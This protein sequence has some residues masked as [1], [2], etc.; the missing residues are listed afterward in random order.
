V[1]G[2]N[3]SIYLYPYLVRPSVFDGLY[4]SLP[5]VGN[6]SSLQVE[7][8][9][10][11]QVLLS[12]V[13]ELGQYSIDQVFGKLGISIVWNLKNGQDGA[14]RSVLMRGQA[15]TTMNYTNVRPLIKTSL[16]FAS[17]NGIVA[18]MAVSL[19]FTG[20]KFV[21]ELTDG[22]AWIVYNGD[23]SL[24]WIVSGEKTLT[25][26]SKI[27]TY[28]RVVHVTDQM[29]A[30]YDQYCNT[31][32]VRVSND[33]YV[34]ENKAKIVFSYETVGNGPFLMFVLPHHIDSMS[35]SEVVFA[36]NSGTNLKLLGTKGTMFG[37]LPVNNQIILYEELT[38]IAFDSDLSKAS[39]S[40]INELRNSLNTDQNIRP[41]DVGN[42]YFFGKEVALMGRLA[43]IA[44]QLNEST[45][46]TNI[47]QAMKQDLNSWLSGG[48]MNNS[49]PNQYVYEKTYGGIVSRMAIASKDPDEEFGNAYYNDHHFHWGYHIYAAAVIAKVDKSWATENKNRLMDLIRDY[50]SPM[51][52]K[53]FPMLRMKD[54]FTGASF[55]QGLFVFGSGVKNQESTSEAINA[56]YAM[57]LLGKVL[58]DYDIEQMGR[59]LLATE[60]RSAKTY[61]H[62]SSSNSVYDYA[63]EFKQNKMVG[64]IWET[65][66]NY[67]TWFGTNLEFIHCIQMMPFTPIMRQVLDTDF[68]KQDYQVLQQ[69]LTRSK[70]VLTEGWRGFIYM[71]HSIFDRQQARKEIDT[72]SSYDDGNCRTNTLYWVISQ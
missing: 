33:F 40:D 20:K 26:T 35:T 38:T 4:C 24:V 31:V 32:P 50:A 28:I 60:I 39:P 34:L 46:A 22:S 1:L 43:L 62:M 57:Y 72:L 54:I 64:I 49:A 18:N 7:L 63:P 67:D 66:A 12:S 59:I 15:Y 71:A 52:D 47:R 27:N 23:P 11:R 69:A 5:S 51:K 48:I 29:D 16:P 19:N 9:E 10:G 41:S 55:A 30:V 21:L 3:N 56:Y 25:A 14:M 2:S 70:P 36:S 61:W 65:A 45:I 13:E 6:V 17:I 53:F 37:I 42:S 68:I 8:G 58:G 44:D